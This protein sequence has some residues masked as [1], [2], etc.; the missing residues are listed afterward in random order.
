[1][2]VQARHLR[3][4]MGDLF[5]GLVPVAATV[6]LASVVLA[7]QVVSP[8]H[9]IIKAGVMLVALIIM[10]RFEM[11]YSLYF[12]VFLFP[13]PSGMLVTSTNILLMT[14][15]TLLWAVRANSAGMRLFARTEI[16]K[17]VILFTVAYLLSFLN[18]E[19]NSDLIEGVKIVWRQLTAFAFFYL[20]VNFVTDEKKLNGIIRVVSASAGFLVLTALIEIGAPGVTLIPGWIKTGQRLGQGELGYRLE[21]LR[22]GG[23]VASH[24]LLSDY[25]TISIF[26][27]AFLFFRARNPIEKLIWALTTMGTFV[28]LLATAN[29]GAFFGLVIGFVYFLYVFRSRFNLVRY[30]IVISAMLSF[31]L[32]AQLL[33]DKYTLAASVTQRMLGTQF[34]GLVPD[35][36][37]GVWEVPLRRSLEHIFVGHGPYFGITPGLERMFWPHNAYIY[38]LFTLGLLGLASFLMIVYRVAKTSFLH[39]HPA[40]RGTFAGSVM[41]ILHVQLLIFLFEQLRTDHQRNTD[42]VYIYIVWMLFGLIVA[43]GKLIRARANALAS[44]T[45]AKDT[46]GP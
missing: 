2:R 12:F 41:G 7:S 25:C 40:A 39:G 37:V 29:R 26:F 3:S 46:P 20:I 44:E 15:L 32:G 13:F 31:F 16:D 6:A 45:A 34:E 33:L 38:Y 1:M 10:L 27:M 23:A 9:R 14:L 28:V 42:F 36:R 30:V 18:V 17:L 5:W 21:S 8:H 24:G 19:Q 22:V 43:T 4:R 11:L 35:S